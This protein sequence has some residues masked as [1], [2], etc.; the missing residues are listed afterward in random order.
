MD[1]LE[2]AKRNYALLIPFF[3]NEEECSTYVRDVLLYSAHS[4]LRIDEIPAPL[5]ALLLEKKE[6][7]FVPKEM[8]V[9]SYLAFERYLLCLIDA[10]LETSFIREFQKAVALD[11]VR[12]RFLLPIVSEN[13]S[14]HCFLDKENENPS[15]YK[16][17]PRGF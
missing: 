1:H 5:E 16:H 14:L 13:V 12:T 17:T 15:L 4:A 9:P 10:L 2:E 7:V 11:K 3:E 8:D 6:G